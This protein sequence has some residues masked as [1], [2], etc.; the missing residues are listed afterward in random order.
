MRETIVRV[1]LTSLVLS[2]VLPSVASADNVGCARRPRIE[3][4]SGL[5]VALGATVA[6]F[7]F[8]RRR[9]GWGVRTRE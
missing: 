7:L 1:F 4:E 8:R 5:A 3:A 6:A 2:T 9:I